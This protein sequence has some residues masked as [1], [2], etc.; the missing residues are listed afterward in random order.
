[1][2]VVILITLFKKI[3][4]STQTLNSFNSIKVTQTLYVYIYADIT[5]SVC[6]YSVTR[7]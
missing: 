2:Y 6:V 5:Q 3:G 7:I 1:M 4:L